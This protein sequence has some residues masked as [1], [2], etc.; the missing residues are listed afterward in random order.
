MERSCTVSLRTQKH[1]H[2]KELHC[3]FHGKE[4]PCFT[5]TNTFM[6]RSCAV[7]LLA[8]KYTLSWKGVAL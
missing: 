3:Y 5:K 4:L 8:Q 6:E 2:G 1:F 7:N